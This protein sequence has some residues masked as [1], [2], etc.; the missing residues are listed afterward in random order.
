MPTD[1]RGSRTSAAMCSPPNSIACHQSTDPD[2][3]ARFCKC[4]F[5]MLHKTNLK[6]SG[7]IPICFSSLCF[8]RANE[9]TEA[10]TK[11]TL[12]LRMWVFLFPWFWLEPSHTQVLLPEVPQIQPPLPD[13]VSEVRMLAV[14]PLG[15]LLQACDVLWS[16]SQHLSMRLAPASTWFKAVKI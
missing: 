13:S 14:L 4:F 7:I 16:A 10:N 11:V 3:G 2:F 5:Y 9:S 12:S 1:S 6:N 15:F 8:F